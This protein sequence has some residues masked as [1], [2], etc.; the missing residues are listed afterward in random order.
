MSGIDQD[1]F[2]EISKN[3]LDEFMCGICQ[4]VV[5]QPRVTQC[6]HQ[7]YC[8]ACITEWLTSN[9]TCPHDRRDLNLGNLT[10]PS[11]IVLNLLNRM[12]VKCEFSGN[13][14]KVITSFE[15]MVKHGQECGHNPDKAKISRVTLLGKYHRLSGLVHWISSAV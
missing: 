9:N 4:M 11:R 13:G 3:V 1:R 7:L 10:T 5:F 6:C 2:V 12:K 14:C 8:N 15:L